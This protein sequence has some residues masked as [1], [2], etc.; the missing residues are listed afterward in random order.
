M[1]AADWEPSQWLMLESWH[2]ALLEEC[3]VARLATIMPGGRPRLVPVCFALVED[4]VFI[5]IDE[6]PKRSSDLARIRDIRRDARVTFLADR[7]D[8]D[9]TRL[10]WVRLEGEARVLSRGSLAPDALARLR[11]RYAQYATMALDELPL[12]ELTPTRVTAWRWSQ[13][14]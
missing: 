3:P 10:A 8:D 9:W 4:R 14:S 13:D 11:Q 1:A 2:R 5:P 12:I 7:Y 6:K